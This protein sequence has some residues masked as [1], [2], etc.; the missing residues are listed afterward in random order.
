MS[1]I[2]SVFEMIAGV[3]VYAINVLNLKDVLDKI[4]VCD[5]CRCGCIRHKCIKVEGCPG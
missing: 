2:E 5:A 1:L 4:N 3:V